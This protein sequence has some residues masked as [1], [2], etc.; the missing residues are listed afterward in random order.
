MN[1]AKNL[2][3][4]AFFF[5]ERP[6]IRI[7]SSVIPYVRF[8]EQVNRVATALLKLGVGPGDHV[9]LCAP[10]SSEWLATYFGAM[11]IGAVAVTLPST[12]T[13]VELDFLIKESIP[14]VIFTSEEK[15]D[16]LTE[17]SSQVC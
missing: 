7:G 14:R 2:E 6:V 9:G 12:L 10:N 4:S 15:R 8:N 17:C 11:K 13:R 1:I 5:P 3:H 16:D